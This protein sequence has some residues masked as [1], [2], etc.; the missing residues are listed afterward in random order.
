MTSIILRVTGAQAKASVHGHLT[1]GMVGIP[2]TIQYDQAWSGLRKNLVCRC[3][4][5]GSG[6]GD[7]RA[8]LNV[9]ATAT[10][11]HEVMKPNMHLY[12]GVEGYSA[13]GK[14][15]IPTIWA[16]CGKIES[17][18]NTG[19]DPSADPTLPVWN[20]LQTEI[21]QIKQNPFTQEQVSEIQACVQSAIQAASSAERSEKNAVAASG[22]AVSSADTARRAADSAQTSMEHARTSAGSAAN[23]ANETL[24]LQRAAEAAAVRA[25]EAASSAQDST[26]AAVVMIRTVLS[27]CDLSNHTVLHP[28]G[29]AYETEIK[30]RDHHV[31][32]SVYVEVGGVDVTKDVYDST[33]HTISI[34]APT[35]DVLIEAFCPERQPEKTVDL[36]LFSGQSNMSGRG[37]GS[38]ATVCPE[39]EGYWY[40]DGALVQ[41]AGDFG[42]E[43]T[44]SSGSMV[45][46]VAKAY[47]D[48]CG[49]PIVA[50]SS[51]YGGTKIAQFAPGE[52]NYT[53]GV[54]LYNAAAAYL[55]NQGYTIRNRTMVWCQGESDGYDGTTQ[56]DYEAAFLVLRDALKADCSITEFFLVE[57]GQYKTDA[58]MYDNIKAAQEH[59]TATE[60]DIIM[61]SRKFIGA[62]GLMKDVW[63]YTQ[64]AYNLVGRDTGI[65]M[66]YYHATGIRPRV[67]EFSAADVTDQDSPVVNDE[68]D[69][70]E[71]DYTLYDDTGLVGLNQYIGSA[72]DV[73]IKAQYK[74]NGINYN[75]AVDRSNKTG[76]W[77][78]IFKGNASIKNVTFEDGVV[79]SQNG[80]VNIN[81]LDSMFENCTA[82]E[83]VYNMPAMIAGGSESTRSAQKLYSG[84]AAVI[85][86]PVPANVKD[87]S[88]CWANCKAL[89]ACAALPETATKLTN[90]FS[91]SGIVN[92]P[93]IPDSVT[94]IQG[95]CQNAASVELVGVIGAGVTA[96]QSAFYADS[97]LSGVVRIESAE[98][99]NMTS[100]FTAA[101]IKRV[102]FEVP[103]NS[104]TY[105]TLKEKYPEASVATF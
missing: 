61:A 84:C 83:H 49:V 103:A 19:E 58:T 23:L 56:T 2:V 53:K 37:D 96:M 77:V 28:S 20:Q 65:H 85:D 97:K 21:E 67:T 72:G 5:Q 26:Q 64:P 40:K 39:G 52:N 16:E 36:V 66:A 51:S 30:P 46:S 89:T 18:A 73:T 42:N 91:G 102:T 44:T 71:W 29:T 17:G 78:P 63:H 60:P 94:I 11:A 86:A 14:L 88:S 47:F 79:W 70:A 27:G 15:V 74:V 22:L 55:E 43:G 48:S 76:S 13:D 92:V 59:L 87:L 105:E 101:I 25:E 98:V 90:A 6:N 4:R 12:L 24:R 69:P 31:A 50:V 33:A 8:I 57:I 100:A 81:I 93:D 35:A 95:L 62:T 1:S 54:E 82:L 34:S 32:G 38:L 3:S 45:S 9:G 80:N 75:T 7:H 99:T 10:V 68:L 104:T 41:I